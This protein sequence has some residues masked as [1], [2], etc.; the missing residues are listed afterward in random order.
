[1][2]CNNCGKELKD[3]IVFCPG[4]GSKV[5]APAPNV[6]RPPQYQGQ[7]TAYGT[8]A[9]GVPYPQRPP[10]PA[11]SSGMGTTMWIAG[12]KIITWIQFAIIILAGIVLGGIAASSIRN[13]LIFFVC[14]IVAFILAFLS[15]AIMMIFLDIASDIHKMREKIEKM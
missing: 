9:N 15:V 4:C 6:A 14:V 5:Q 11:A 8:P 3:G 12:L 1:M 13:P 2:R 7:P 10:H